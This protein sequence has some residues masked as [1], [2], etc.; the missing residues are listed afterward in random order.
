VVQSLFYEKSVFLRSPPKV[1]YPETYLEAIAKAGISGIQLF[2]GQLVVRGP[3][4]SLQ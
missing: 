3:G 1:D 2:H 4:A